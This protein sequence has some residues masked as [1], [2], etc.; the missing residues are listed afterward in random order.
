MS[1]K[2]QIEES[3]KGLILDNNRE[4]VAMLSGEWGI[5]KTYFWRDFSEKYLKGKDVVYIS[6]FGKNSLADIETEIVTKLYKYNKGLKK[7]TKHLD[8]VGNMAS[9]AM[10]LPINVSIGSLLSLFK[11]SDF[12]NTIICFDDFERLSDKVPLKDVM[13]LI[14]QFKEQKECKVIMILNEKELDKLSGI[15]GKKHDEI[16]TLYKEKVVDYNFQ[17]QPNQEELFQAIKED[18]DKITFGEHQTIYDFFKKIDLKNIRIMKQALYQ[19]KHFEF[20]K[21]YDLNEK[22]INEFVEIAL[23][24]FVFKAKSNYSYSDFQSMNEYLASKMLQLA[25]KDKDSKIEANE[26]FDKVS[27]YYYLKDSYIFKKYQSRNKALIEETIYTFIDTHKI[28]K[29]EL[30]NLLDENNQSL[31]WYDMR[32]EISEM[33]KRLFTDFSTSNNQLVKQLFQLISKYK[34][35]M[36]RLFQYSVYTPFIKDINEFAPEIS[37][38]ELEIEIAKKYLHFYIISPNHDKYGALETESETGLIIYHYSWAEE[39]RKK[40][41]RDI[42]KIDTNDILM[43]IENVL[44]NRYLSQ[45][46]AYKL[47]QISADSYENLI[48]GNYNFIQP[49][50]DFLNMP[51]SKDARTNIINALKSLKNKSDDYAWKVK[52]IAKSTNINLKEEK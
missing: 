5:G 10:G 51:N 45:D 18:I 15:D 22:V 52:Q 7:Y 47:N 27:H 13:G 50:V 46:N 8:T 26:K 33:H 44:S 17:Y 40:C 19:L 38:K 42:L 9:K 43:L 35:N 14:S 32:N 4:F 41:K 20:I 37:T 2:Q 11:A 31:A 49:L 30:Q 1:N 34:D 6:L 21:N 28:N 12:K 48:T 39:Y 29:G 24:L 23:N 25:L 36:H 16:F 3:L